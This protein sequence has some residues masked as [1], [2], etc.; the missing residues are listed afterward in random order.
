VSEQRGAEQANK[1]SD[2]PQKASGAD[3]K[4][5]AS[6]GV[7][8]SPEDISRLLVQ[9]QSFLTGL[10]PRRDA[11]DEDELTVE[12][13]E[14]YAKVRAFLSRRREGG[15]GSLIDNLEDAVAVIAD[16]RDEIDSYL[17]EIDLEPE[18]RRP[19]RRLAARR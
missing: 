12:D 6:H 5:G 19:T 16:A 11:A 4:T 14:S 13:L 9:V 3:K 17:D 15:L 8:P 2:S 7:A 10:L 18:R 1:K